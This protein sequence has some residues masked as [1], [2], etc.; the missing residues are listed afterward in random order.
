MAAEDFA[1]YAK[2]YPSAFYLV[3]TKNEQ[4]GITSELHTSTF[5]ID[6]AIYEKSVEF[7]FKATVSLLQKL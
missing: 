3:G 1:Y 5:D 6:E 2:K 4:K 7:M